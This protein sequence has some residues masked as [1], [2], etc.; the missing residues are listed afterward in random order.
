MHDNSLWEKC[1]IKNVAGVVW[2]SCKSKPWL[3]TVGQEQKNNTL[4]E[5]FQNI[6]QQS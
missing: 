2:E 4:S 3:G 5:H 6:I 1:G